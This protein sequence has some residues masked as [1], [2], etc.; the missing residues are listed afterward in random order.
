M[1]YTDIFQRNYKVKVI[2]LL[3]DPVCGRNNQ[4]V[5]ANTGYNLL[6]YAY[7]ANTTR[8]PGVGPMLCQRRRRW[9]S[10]GPTPGQRVVFAGILYI[11]I[12]GLL[13]INLSLNGTS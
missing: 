11:H 9:R 6:S 8:C 1:V 7:P 13:H 3:V 10:V 12:I 4:T 2:S 5:V